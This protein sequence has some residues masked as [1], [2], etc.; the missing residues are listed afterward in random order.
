MRMRTRTSHVIPMCA[1][2]YFRIVALTKL[3]R[4]SALRRGRPRCS[5]KAMLSDKPL[6]QLCRLALLICA[7]VSPSQRSSVHAQSPPAEPSSA[8][9]S[10][11]IC[12]TGPAM[13]ESNSIFV[14]GRQFISDSGEV[15]CDGF[16][17]A[18]RFCHYVIGFRHLE[19]A[20]W[21]GV[22]RL[23][24]D[25]YH[26]V[27]LNIIVVQPPGY[28]EE[29]LRCV[30]HKVDAFDW[31]ETKAGDYIGFYLPENGVFVA[32]ASPVMDPDHQQLQLIEYGY[33]ETFNASQV[34]VAASSTGRA[35]LGADIGK[36]S[37]KK[38]HELSLQYYE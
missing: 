7:V 24:G 6:L 17:T 22:W 26:Q 37:N 2:A 34:E 27:G 13:T 9:P 11:A 32:S 16:I 18:W 1:H 29:R 35:L 3:R 19:M 15:S 36:L 38:A 30:D 4:R 25:N 23:E 31:I 5:G 33:A 28:D 12:T 10:Q 8:P 20:I 14:N 21:A